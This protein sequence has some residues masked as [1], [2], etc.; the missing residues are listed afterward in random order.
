M[1]SDR[2]SKRT[3]E[4]KGVKENCFSTLKEEIPNLIEIQIN[5]GP[6]N[7]GGPP[8][9]SECYL[10]LLGTKSTWVFLLYEFQ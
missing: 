5:F 9:F 2:E 3:E 1:Y 6:T 7:I 10:P 8:N 4:T